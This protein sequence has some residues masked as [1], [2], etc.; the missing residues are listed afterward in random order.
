MS[1][2]SQTRPK[3][4][5]CDINATKI[6]D[7][8]SSY[9]FTDAQGN[10]LGGIRRKGLISLWKA[11]YEI[12]SGNTDGATE[13]DVIE[14][15]VL[16]RILDA[17]FERIPIVGL[18]SGYIA[19]PTYIVNDSSGNA[20]MRLRKNPSLFESNFSIES[21]S[22]LSDPK[23]IQILLSLLMFVLLEQNRG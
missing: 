13:F 3:K 4:N 21:L 7:W 6:I 19:N 20:V 9:N 10:F 11:R 8:S 23:Q 14:E 2:Y 5:L 22:E 17:I 12:Y 15:S 1:R 18:L 16:A